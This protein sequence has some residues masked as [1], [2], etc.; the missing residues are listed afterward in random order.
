MAGTDNI[1]DF[2]ESFH[3]I[4]WDEHIGMCSDEVDIELLPDIEGDKSK[5]CIGLNDIHQTVDRKRLAEFFWA[6]AVF[7]DSDQEWF[8]VGE[9]PSLNK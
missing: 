8:K 4:K 7:L 5:V 1:I 3:Y 6:A 2:P 9:Y